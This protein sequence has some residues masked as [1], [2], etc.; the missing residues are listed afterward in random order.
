MEIILLIE[1]EMGRHRTVK[2]APRIIDIDILFYD[3]EIYASPRLTIP[4]PQLQNRRF[5]LIPLNELMPR[6]KHPLLQK[7]IHELLRDCVDTL[8]VHKYRP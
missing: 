4:H 6:F 7:T 8:E 3:K 2:N 1:E 5:V